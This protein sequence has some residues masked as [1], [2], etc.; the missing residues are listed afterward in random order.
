[1]LSSTPEAVEEF[2]RCDDHDLSS[3]ILFKD[4]FLLIRSDIVVADFNNPSAGSAQEILYA[5]LMDIPIL[6]ISY[7]SSV[8]PWLQNR[9]VAVA[10]PKNA[11][12][13]IRLVIGALHK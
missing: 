3:Q 10:A 2:I 5:H 9:A 11:D 4:L 7:R 12:D 1:M 13:I 6:G 8:S